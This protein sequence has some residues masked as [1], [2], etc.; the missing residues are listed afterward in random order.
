MIRNRGNVVSAS[1]SPRDSAAL[2]QLLN[3]GVQHHQ[4]G[5]LVEAETH[6]RGVLEIDPDQ[7]DALHLLGLIA[8]RVG[9]HDVAV[10]L[11]GR[12]IARDGDNPL[13]HSNLGLA[14]QGLDRLDEA[15]AS[16]DGAIKLRADYAEAHF[17]RG[18][19][20]QRLKRFADALA[21]YDR[22]L[23]IRPRDADA[24]ANRGATL[25]ELARYPDAL[26]SCERAL[27]LRPDFLNALANR[28]NALAAL[29]RFEEALASY[30]RALALSPD[31][32]EVAFH[33]GNV[34]Q[35]L[36]R[37][38]EAVASYERVLEAR[39]ELAEA[40]VNRGNALNAAGRLDQAL[41]SYERALALRG[42]DADALYNRG[43]VQQGLRR[44]SEALAS[45][46]A[47]LAH[48]PD[49]ARALCNRGI[50]LQECDRRHDALES[51]DRAIAL[52]PD[53][54]EAHCNRGV[55]LQ[56][57][58]RFDE[59]LESFDRA[60]A[61]VPDYGDALCNRGVA[62]RE[63]SRFD[64]ALASFARAI[65]LRPDHAGAYSNRGV[66]L[67]ALRR[68]GE[69]GASFDRALALSPNSAEAHWNKALLQLQT[70]DFTAGWRGYEWRRKLDGF[71]SRDLAG[72]EW[73]GEP[74]A[75]MRLL[76][77]TEQG[78]GDTIQFVRYVELAAAQGARVVLEVQP[79]LKALL[80]GLPGVEITIAKGEPLPGYD[81]HCSLLS[82]PRAFATTVE[83]VPANAPY[84]AAPP[85]RIARWSSRLPQGAPRV[86][87]AWSGN[88]TYA[89]DHDRSIALSELAPLLAVEGVRFVS[90][91]KDVRV[92]DAAVLHK[93]PGIIDISADLG[94]F[95]DT[96]AV[97][98]QLDLVISV[99]TAVAHLAGAMG[100]PVWILLPS[101][102]DFRWLL[103]RSDSPWYPSARLLRASEP[104][105]W[106]DVVA[107]VTGALA[108]VCGDHFAT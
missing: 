17:N 52:Q 54:A 73:M 24:L 15:L 50:V 34:L 81:L 76:L 69:A 21:A 71:V 3:A 7:A 38:D 10:N 49:H 43:V 22:L 94:D 27:A 101:L 99:D 102:P 57:L 84:I 29:K 97:I 100:K 30:D 42:D 1:Q 75:G 96:A 45:Y 92:S 51:F 4:A 18:V 105:Q 23:V 53:L 83:T 2:A 90:L 20:L 106:G 8:S 64:E 37:Y 12:A 14:L 93:H 108:A 48:H 28:G 13:Y 74:L 66:A 56:K 67:Q 65:A 70:G 19:V 35:E 16:F 26:S 60:L 63:L 78:L 86:G 85:D 72:R 107:K 33:R 87:L 103:D 41:E 68:F 79:A 40:W 62:L 32:A 88:P 44:W 36:G 58:K 59:A 61:L 6:Y 11:I 98:A 80:A 95:V 9:R 31:Q 82:L 25:L 46:D 47:A 5:R 77:H 39:P 104:R 89:R 91:Q 55:V